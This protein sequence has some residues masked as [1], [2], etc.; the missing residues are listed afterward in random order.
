MLAF[1]ITVIEDRA[2]SSASLAAAVRGLEAALAE[3]GAP[4]ER[5]DPATLV[6]GGERLARSATLLFVVADRRRP[7]LEDAADGGD[8]LLEAVRAVRA[9][10][11]RIPIYLVGE[12]LT[13]REIHVDVIAEIEGVVNAHEDT[14]SFLARAIE[15]Q[16][17]EY[18]DSLAP[19]FFR[20]LMR[21]AADGAYSWH[22]PGHSGGTAF[23]KSPV[24]TVF[25]DFF[26]ERMLRADV[27]NA[28]EELGQLLDHTGP[29][30]DSE[31]RAARTF[32]SD[33]LYFVTNGTSTS[34]K[35][36][37]NSLVGPGD[38]V[39]VDRNCHKSIL[40]AIMLT[41]A[42]PIYLTPTR[43]RAGIIGPIPR[44]EFDPE[45]IRAKMRA[46]P[47]VAD[48]EATPR[49]FTLTQSTYDGI[50]YNA[51]EIKAGLDGEVGALHFDEAW[52]PH[53]A[54][55]PLYDDMH[56]ID[57]DRG[58]TDSSLVFATQSTHKLLAGLS[59]A[60]QILVQNAERIELD[61]SMFNEA[62]LMHTSTSPQY[63]IIASCDVSAEMMA[64]TGGEALVAEAITE[65]MEFRRAIIRIG[66]EA[67]ARGD[68]W[69]DV[70]GPDTPP[71][72]GLPDRAEWMI[73]ADAPWHGFD[74]VDEGFT[75]LD[76]IKVTLTTPGLSVRGEYD[77]EGIPGILLA[78]YL[79]EHG[80]VVEK[81]GLYSLFILF[82]IGVTKGRW[83][84]LIGALHRFKRAYDG[85]LPVEEAMPRFASA[86]PRYARE[87]LRDLAARLHR[88]NIDQDVANLATDIYL[89]A[90]EMAMLPAHAWG[91]M[92]AGRVEHV[93]IAELA[94]RT[95]AVLLTPYPP[96]IPLVV[97]GE[98]ISAKIVEYLLH[99]SR[100]ADEFPGFN[101]ITHG[102]ADD[103]RG[104]RTVP[105]IVEPTS[106]VPTT[107]SPD[108]PS[109]TP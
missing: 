75:M 70:W 46:N 100:L 25:S 50:V 18:L 34:N 79:A 71:R 5:R 95:T 98:R 92:T 57:T 85:N 80:V 28:V 3:I 32:R 69:F 16:A 9:K 101:G 12:Q 30:A 40:H 58:R 27:C 55:H 52:L 24:G 20:A 86:H 109:S 61:T 83:N 10:N 48:A 90:P 65:A 89:E 13:A 59:Q 44:R 38:V 105:C 1:P 103:G 42:V 37:W 78:R 108:A 102:L 72:E 4:T 76:P 33:H 15:R 93:P 21:Y 77:E 56:A 29:V 8:P 96:G 66:E 82:T 87:G 39:V 84:T 97:P 81:T 43:N 54:F 6:D 49:I 91:A 7:G 64:G 22:C 67:R 17:R 23:L 14:P 35:I 45:S 47:F 11:A 19:P 60:S 51:A 88:A 36:V 94:G 53:A 104:R 63:A 106:G 73:S 62:Y 26:G 68:W 107:S 2:A 99:E 74:E 31:R 41:G